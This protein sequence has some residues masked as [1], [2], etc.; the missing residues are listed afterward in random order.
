MWRLLFPALLL[1][2][3]APL[4]A[5]SKGE[6]L[7]IE[8][9]AACH[10][11]DG[12]GGVGTPLA[13]KSFI[14]TVSDDY[15]AE[16][17]R[18]GRPGRIM[19]TFKYLGDDN[20]EA[21]VSHLRSWS[22]KPAPVEHGIKIAGN[23]ENGRKLFIQHC[24]RCHGDNGE[25]GEGTGVTFSRPRDLPII[26]P[27]LNNPGFLAAASNQMIRNTII[28]GREGTPMRPYKEKLSD[29]QINDITLFIRSLEG[30]AKP[31][32]KLADNTPLILKVETDN[33][34]EETVESVTDAVTSQNFVVIRTGLLE[35]GLFP[36][37]KENQ[38]AVFVD[39]CSFSFLNQA[40]KADPRIGIFL[41][42]RVSIIEQE[43][44][45]FLMTVNPEALGSL[46]NNTSLDEACHN[47]SEIYKAILNEATL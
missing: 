43:G 38:K 3:C 21:I 23:P 1:F 15:L 26:P 37:G 44:K 8:H 47:M 19:P 29:R 46:F 20:I 25:G 22:N 12:M 45:V 11:L 10:G 41:P 5:A 7:F 18:Q 35:Y 40:L 16:T 2:L 17:I 24:S 9:C 31:P 30:S 27:A 4:H 32:S 33:S 14:D 39:F 6:S 13:L 34:F 28:N 36:E 42:C